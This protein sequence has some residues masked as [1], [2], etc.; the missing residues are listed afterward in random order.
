MGAAVESKFSN[1]ASIAGSDAEVLRGA[2]EVK[3][4]LSRHIALLLVPAFVAGAA[5]L[6]AIS[7]WIGAIVLRQEAERSSL[8]T[9]SLFEIGLRNSMLQR[10]LDGLERLITHLGTLPGVRSAELMTPAGEVRFSSRP[11]Q[12]GQDRATELNKLCLGSGCGDVSSASVRWSDGDQAPRLTVTYPVL[13]QV[14]CAGCHGQTTA[15]PVNGVL[16]LEFQPSA[17]D[18]AALSRA[19]RHLLPASLLVLLALGAWVAWILR[20][21]VLER[22]QSMIS[23]TNRFGSGDL[24]ARSAIRGDDELSQ[25]GQGFNR[26]AQEIETQVARL[27]QH[28]NYLQSLLDGAPDAMLIIG[29]DHRIVMANAAYARLV[30]RPLNDIVGRNC[31]EASRDQ[32]EACPSTMINCPLVE[33]LHSRSGSR[34]VMEF[35]HSDGPRVGV[36]VDAAPIQGQDGRWQVM[37][38][39]RPVHERVR[40]SQEQRLSA[41]GLLANGVAHEVHNPLASIRLA[42]QACLRGL[43]DN[44]L[45]REELEHYLRIVDAQIDRCVNITQRL[46]RLSQPPAEHPAPV[47]VQG[48]IDDVLTVL[49]EEIRRA[50]V[51]V[52]VD[53]VDMGLR[54]KGDEGELRQ[55]LLNLLQNALHAL[56]QGGGEVILRG[57]RESG[58]VRMDVLDNGVGIAADR[59]PLIFLPFY[60]RRADG[61]RG[62]GLGL[63]ICRSLVEQRGGWIRA[64]SE[65]GQGTRIEWALPDADAVSLE[66]VS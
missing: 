33:C 58:L 22:L 19:G 2:A 17:G 20:R 13:N 56:A 57:W 14:A 38:V 18:A 44:T 62:T 40:F 1:E 35:V 48:A 23:A 15:N 30:G 41:V 28:G 42:L 51:Q 49:S 32:S 4:R 46:M 25:L 6:L 61:Q 9:A 55:I 53:W 64:F 26:M 60:S 63:A 3:S 8:S 54:V 50:S 21:S 31:Y 10:D 24:K 59:L 47:S 52:R 12:R 5:L 65:P 39:I 27:A 11:G 45:E 7:A 36:E 43:A 34:T 29:D 66:S 37:E 16:L